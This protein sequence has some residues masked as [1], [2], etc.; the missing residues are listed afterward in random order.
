MSDLSISDDEL[1]ML[2]AMSGEMGE[3]FTSPTPSVPEQ[4]AQAQ[5]VKPPEAP[6]QRFLSQEDIDALLTGMKGS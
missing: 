1:A 6:Q 2:L 4:P 3:E 5:P